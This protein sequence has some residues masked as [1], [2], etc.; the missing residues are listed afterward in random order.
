[1]C[2]HVTFRRTS[3]RRPSP[4][5]SVK[6]ETPREK[7]APARSKEEDPLRSKV[8]GTRQPHPVPKK[9]EERVPPEQKTC[10]HEKVSQPCQPRPMKLTKALTN[11]YRTCRW[12]PLFV[13][14]VTNFSSVLTLNANIQAHQC[15][16]SAESLLRSVLRSLNFPVL[17][18]TFFPLNL[19]RRFL[20]YSNSGC[21]I[22]IHCYF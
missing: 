5:K 3:N 12:L 13:D 4:A 8:T 16:K 9:Q 21:S 19:Q 10:L 14:S 2:N 7:K 20:L 22:F 11:K 1:M 15:T 6:K 18:A 17:P